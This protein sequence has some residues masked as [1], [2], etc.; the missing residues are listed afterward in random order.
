M[1]KVLA[2]V[3]LVAGLASCNAV[4]PPPPAPF[5]ILIRVESD[6]GRPLPGAIIMKGGK[7]G[8]STGADG[9]IVLKI[10]GQEGE[11]VDLIV[12]CPADYVTSPKPLSVSLRRG[13]K[14]P[15][16]SWSCPPAIRHM[17][18]AVRAENG[19]NLPVVWFGRV[20][21]RTDAN[22]AFT[23]LFPLRPGDPLELTLDTS[24]K[25]NERIHPK[26]PTGAFVMKAYDD[27]VTFDQKFNWDPIV[28]HYVKRAIPI[29]IMPKKENYHSSSE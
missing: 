2:G 4:Q 13:S 8:P 25:A 23:A 20:I 1:R 14:L 5:E 28:Y 6:P 16:Y 18:V 24:D 10:P 7:E 22:G 11:S 15:E 26:N 19:P 12:R 27:V 29:R 17:V 21:G 9:T 3:S